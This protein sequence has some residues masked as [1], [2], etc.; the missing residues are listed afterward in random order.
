M[1]THGEAPPGAQGGQWKWEA[2]ELRHPKFHGK[3]TSAPLSK[4]S[5]A[6]GFRPA[7]QPGIKG[8]AWLAPTHPSSFI[9]RDHARCLELTALWEDHTVF[10]PSLWECLCSGGPSPLQFLRPHPMQ[11]TPEEITPSRLMLTLESLSRKCPQPT[12]AASSRVMPLF[13][14][15][16][17]PTPS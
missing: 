12:C 13:W 11:Q 4:P 15:Q 9:S 6:T 14:D 7:L 3:F 1:W 10:P 16:P 2:P 17:Q 8:P 5:Q